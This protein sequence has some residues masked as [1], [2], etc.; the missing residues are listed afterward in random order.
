MLLLQRTQV[1]LLASILDDSQPPVAPSPGA[2]T[3]PSHLC[4]QMHAHTHTE[5]HVHANLK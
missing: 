2:L 4:G 1:Q 3:P 5:M